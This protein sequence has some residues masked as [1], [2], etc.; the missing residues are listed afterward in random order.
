MEEEKQTSIVT[1]FVAG[2]LSV[3]S[4]ITVVSLYVLLPSIGPG[5]ESIT[6]PDENRLSQYSSSLATGSTQT[7]PLSFPNIA[8]N[9]PSV[10]IGNCIDE[11]IKQ[12]VGEAG[13]Y[14]QGEKIT[15]SSKEANIN[16][17]F[18]VAIAQAE[19]ALGTNITRG[20]FNYWNFLPA[21][22]Y[23]YDFPS[24][25]ES[26]TSHTQEI[27]N[28]FDRGQNNIIQ[29]GNGLNGTYVPVDSTKYSANDCNQAV[30]GTMAYCPCGRTS[31]GIG[32]G[33]DDDTTHDPNKVNQY[34][35][36][37]VSRF[38]DKVATR[39]N[40][41]SPRPATSGWCLPTSATLITAT[42]LDP[43]YKL[44][45]GYDHYGID[46]APTNSSEYNVYASNSGVVIETNNT[47]P[48]GS[49]NDSCGGYFGNF[50]KIDH[51]N[52]YVSIYAHL[53]K[54]TLKVSQGDIVS[55]KELIANI[56][57]SGNSNG[58]H[59]HF[60]VRYNGTAIDPAS[61]PLGNCQ[62]S[63]CQTEATQAVSFARQQLGKIYSQ[64]NPIG[65]INASSFD[66][67]GLFGSAWYYATNDTRYYHNII[68]SFENNHDIAIYHPSNLLSEIQPGD[69][70]FGGE[71]YGVQSANT[72]FQQMGIY[73]G[74]SNISG[75]NYQH[76]VI[77][78][79]PDYGIIIREYSAGSW[80]ENT[81]ARPIACQ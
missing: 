45:L 78:A 62:S 54:D 64:D 72:D 23:Y 69:A 21:P 61:L 49:R 67:A 66:S 26:I 33:T 31:G 32:Y 29:I 10:E 7:I 46:Y 71:Y 59:L 27:K 80:S 28:F 38:F 43:Q 1:L 24:W 34:W 15:D 39:C 30:V 41:L 75:Q 14:G 9:I 42:F 77:E 50:I 12:E 55:K 5:F 22:D 13:L 25:E 79:S 70:L 53:Q 68:P 58:D 48:R 37:N 73:I 40:F 56:D 16:P 4:F 11:Y 57:S 17:A 36:G 18:T 76:G 52:G 63:P 8:L 2:L 47:C 60:E 20:N 6:I 65:D 35:I 74:Q 51:Q 3:I 44:L 19:S 81:F